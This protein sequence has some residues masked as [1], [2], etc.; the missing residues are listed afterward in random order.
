MFKATQKELIFF[1]LFSVVMDDTCKA[2]DILLELFTSLSDMDSKIQ[3]IEKLEHSCDRTVH[4]IA[5]HINHSF[6]T[7]IDREDIMLIAKVLDNIIDDIEE[8][9]QSLLLYSITKI[10]PETLGMAEQIVKCTRVLSS[11]IDELKNMKTSNKIQSLIVEVNEIENEGDKIY[12][13]VIK[14]LFVKEQNP[15]E[16]IKWKDIISNMEATLDDCEDVANII[17]GIVSK[18]A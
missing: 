9:A 18:N 8:T 17:E 10:R 13:S 2:A 6:V 7:P 15:L 12:N 5:D 3:S 4:D 1:D 11:L 16:I 14:N